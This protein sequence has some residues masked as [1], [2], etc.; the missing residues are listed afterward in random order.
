[1]GGRS[2]SVAAR[3]FLQT[4]NFEP[5]DDLGT[6]GGSFQC[7]ITAVREGGPHGK[8]KSG[9]NS[10]RSCSACLT[11]KTRC[12]SAKLSKRGGESLT[13]LR[14]IKERSKWG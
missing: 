1:V 6:L 7:G 4:I 14:R 2:L 13:R 11:V 12:V 10:E 8:K 5:R 3:L 9:I